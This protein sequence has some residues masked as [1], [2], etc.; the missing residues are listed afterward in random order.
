MK[1]NFGSVE[2]YSNQAR[3]NINLGWAEQNFHNS[4]G[5]IVRYLLCSWR[6]LNG[7]LEIMVLL[8]NHHPITINRYKLHICRLRQCLSRYLNQYHQLREVKLQYKVRK[9]NKIILI[10]NILNHLLRYQVIVMLWLLI[11]I[12][13]LVI[14]NRMWN[15]IRLEL[16]KVWGWIKVILCTL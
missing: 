5:D 3:N 8:Y 6:K 10:L 11:Q 9:I 7:Y 2:N 1:F 4:L 16:R 12:L 14:R 15:R 13:R